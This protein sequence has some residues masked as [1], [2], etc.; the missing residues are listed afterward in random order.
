MLARYE[1]ADWTRHIGVDISSNAVPLE[2][3]LGIALDVC[4]QLIL[5]AI[6]AVSSE[7]SAA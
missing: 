1:P 4:P 7:L 5:H 2:A 6:R 3:V